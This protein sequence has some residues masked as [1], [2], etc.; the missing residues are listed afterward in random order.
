MNTIIENSLFEDNTPT[1]QSD[2][3]RSSYL[4]TYL[5][6]D[7]YTIHYLMTTSQKLRDSFHYLW[8]DWC[9]SRCTT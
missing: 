6:H 5:L 4:P 3:Y 7:M 1:Y 8:D 9:R 2:E